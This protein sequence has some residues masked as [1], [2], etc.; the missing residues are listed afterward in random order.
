MIK[1]LHNSKDWE[2]VRIKLSHDLL[3]NEIMPAVSKELNVLAG[4]VE[5]SDFHEEFCGMVTERVSRLCDG[6]EELTEC[7]EQCLSPRQY[8]ER[9]PLQNL[10]GISKEWLQVVVHENW[11]QESM[12]PERTKNAMECARMVRKALVL[13]GKTWE[14]VSNQRSMV[15]LEL[16]RTLQYFASVI[17]DMGRLVPYR[18]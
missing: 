1:R 2:H 6:F 5:D 11:V 15:V 18:I 3:K 13:V 14:H 10:D 17:A 4:K 7:A 8:F 16:S 12:L 9:H